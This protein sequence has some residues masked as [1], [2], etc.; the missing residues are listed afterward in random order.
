MTTDRD[1]ADKDWLRDDPF[2]LVSPDLAIFLLVVG[3]A[4]GFL[5][6]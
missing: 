1:Y 2:Q 6:A 3:V 5:I 4:L